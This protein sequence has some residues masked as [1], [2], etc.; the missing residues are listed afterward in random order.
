MRVEPRATLELTGAMVCANRSAWDGD[1]R[2]RVTIGLF[3]GRD[4][5]AVAQT[6]VS[7]A[8]FPSV[9]GALEPPIG[10]GLFRVV[11]TDVRENPF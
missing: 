10:A 2:V 1:G 9:V 6:F 8:M 4:F 11:D 7:T 5:Y 3:S